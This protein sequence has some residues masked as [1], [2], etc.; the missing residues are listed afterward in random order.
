MDETV[1]IPYDKI[2]LQ[3]LARLVLHI[4]QN[5]FGIQITLEEQ[6][7]LIDIPGF[8]LAGKGNFWLALR[9]GVVVG[10]IALKDIGNGQGALR[11]MFVD[12]RYRGRQYGVG[13]DL[14]DTLLVWAREKGFCEILLGTTDKFLA[15]HRFYEKNG[16][17]TTPKSSLPQEFPVASVDSIF[18]RLML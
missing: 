5:E 14:L 11:K 18:Y 9:N 16:F 2:Y 3:D 7:D 17:F 4:Q 6:P 12:T 8:F 10:C 13:Q 1:I 15:A